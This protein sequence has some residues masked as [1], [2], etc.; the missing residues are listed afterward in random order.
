MQRAPGLFHGRYRTAGSGDRVICRQLALTG[1][2]ASRCQMRTQDRPKIAPVLV[3]A[4]NACG[5]RLPSSA[6]VFHAFSL[7]PPGTC[8]ASAARAPRVSARRQDASITDVGGL[9]GAPGRSVRNDVDWL[10]CRC[11]IATQLVEERKQFG[12]FLLQQDQ[13]T[14]VG[15]LHV[16]SVQ[17]A[18]QRCPG[19]EQTACQP[20]WCWLGRCDHAH[21]HLRSGG[22]ELSLRFGVHGLQRHH[23][24]DASGRHGAAVVG[25]RGR[26]CA[27]CPVAGASGTDLG[28]LPV[29]NPA[30]ARAIAPG[31]AA[32]QLIAT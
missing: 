10:V 6:R 9:F 22:F 3:H 23:A 25:K 31:S 26:K 29:G 11:R 14:F 7:R 19:L 32:G 16:A 17:D 15:F 27:A 21:Q 4:S 18:P 30:G 28:D 20:V 24:G 1:C 13:G 8:H 2:R 5:V 12:G